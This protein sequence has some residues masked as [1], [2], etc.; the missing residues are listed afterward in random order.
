M[1]DALFGWLRATR[2]AGADAQDDAQR[3][4]AGCIVVPGE[5][6]TNAVLADL[7]RMQDAEGAAW[8]ALL[9]HALTATSARPSRTWLRAARQHL[10]ALGEAAFKQHALGWLAEAAASETAANLPRNGD[11]LR[12][13]IWTCSLLDAAEAAR[14][15]ADLGIAFYKKIRGVGPRSVK[16]GNACIYALGAMSG[17]EAVAQLTRLRLRVKDRRGVQ[18]IDRALETAAARRGLTADDLEELAVPTYGLEG[19]AL[20]QPL[21]AYT[22]VLRLAGADRTDLT[23]LRPDGKRQKSVPAAVRRAHPEAVKALK[24]TAKDLRA[25]LAAQRNRLER[26]LRADHSRPLTA[27]RERYRDHPLVSRLARRLVWQITRA[28]DRTLAAWH[29]GRLVDGA[30]RPLEDLSEDA[31]VRLWHPITSDAETVLAWRHWLEAREVTQPFKQAHRE[32][33]LLT[34]AERQTRTYSNRFAAHVLVQHQLAA[35]C[36]ARGWTYRL[37]GA[38][39]GC[40]EPTLALP[41]WGLRAAFLIETDPHDDHLTEAGLFLH[42]T[43]DQVRFYELDDVMGHGPLPLEE[44]PPLVFS[45]V[46]RDVDLF[47]GVCSVGNDPTWTDRG[48]DAGF[49]RYFDYWRA[50][51]FGGLSA[52]AQTRKDVLTRLLPRLTIAGRCRLDG[53]FLVVRGDLRTYKIHLG[54]GN[55]LMAPNDQY[56]CIVPDARAASRNDAHAVFLPFEGDRTLSLI[57]SKAF[58]LADDTAIDDP[59]ITRQINRR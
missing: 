35:L 3:P 40:N 22:A 32:V 34:D 21:G 24:K 31:S 58:L 29:E 41:R 56:L 2:R 51:A 54:S 27:W 45:E 26:L 44:I 18:Q 16:V 1:L 9:R 43:S 37:Q 49:E 6:W 19:G 36:R 33:Y 13:L 42:V 47:V 20:R 10:D 7:A 55:I 38:F 50:F 30:G 8:H 17:R 4:D 28:D 46:M 12:G 59:T 5:A 23:W 14:A 39:D 48:A 52:T 53:R 25:M 11:Q 57:L 15:V